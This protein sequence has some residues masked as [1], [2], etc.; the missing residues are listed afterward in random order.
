MENLSLSRIVKRLWS[1]VP[2][3]GSLPEDIWHKRHRFLVGLIW[4]HA[5]LIALVGPVLGYRWELSLNALFHDGT[6]VHTV[7]YGLIVAFFAV[8][9]VWRRKSRIFRATALGLGLMSSSA[10]L[11]H[12]SGGYFE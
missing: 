6:V 2:S 7:A 1:F 11:V 3:G 10:I 9:A 5:I 12:L 8:L 4:F